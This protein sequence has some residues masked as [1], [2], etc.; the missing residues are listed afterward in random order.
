MKQKYEQLERRQKDLENIIVNIVTNTDTTTLNTTMNT[1]T[2][3]PQTIVIRDETIIDC[4][5]R[6]ESFYQFLIEKYLDGTH[7]RLPSGTTD[8]TTN[9]IHA[10]IK[11]W[12][13][14]KN[15]IGQLICYNIDAPKETLHAYLFGK[16]PK[17]TDTI[18]NAFNVCKIKPFYFVDIDECICVKDQYDTTI[19]KFQ[20][21]RIIDK[22]E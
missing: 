7:Y 8:V 1:L 11:N 13:S 16:R 2:T 5:K 6:N 15:A 12:D 22:T 9:T 19:I 14:W 18:F 4:T 10:E 3:L 17:S 20:L 21:I